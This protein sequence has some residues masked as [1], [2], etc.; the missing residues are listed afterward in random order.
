MSY[1]VSLLGVWL[2]GNSYLT[3]ET[4]VSSLYSKLKEKI[5]TLYQDKLVTYKDNF[6]GFNSTYQNLQNFKAVP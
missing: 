1:A 3:Y 5:L 4:P 6:Q 2:P